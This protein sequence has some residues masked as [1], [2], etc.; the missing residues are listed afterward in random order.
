MDMAIIKTMLIKYLNERI[1][2]LETLIGAS[3]Y[4]EIKGAAHKIKGNS[5]SLALGLSVF[6]DI[7]KKMERA[8]IDHEPIAVIQAC[9][10]ELKAEYQKI[11]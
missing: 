1:I 7:G 4:D 8:A 10:D 9:L 11:C 3:N 2:E 6:N 5:G